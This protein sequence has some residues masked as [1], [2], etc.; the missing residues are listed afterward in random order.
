M[1]PRMMPGALEVLLHVELLGHVEARG[2]HLALADALH[3]EDAHALAEMAV[4][5]EV[6]P[7]AV[8]REVKRVRRA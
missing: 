1:S 2:Q 8:E 7:A 5:D 4:A 3:G 6:E